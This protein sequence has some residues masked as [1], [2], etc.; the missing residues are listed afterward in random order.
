MSWQNQNLGIMNEDG[1][2]VPLQVNENFVGECIT[3]SDEDLDDNVIEEI[4]A[5]E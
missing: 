3:L 4:Y 2:C 5:I 1:F